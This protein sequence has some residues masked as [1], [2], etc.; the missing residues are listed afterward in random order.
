MPSPAL[1][2]TFLIVLCFSLASW[3]Q[4]RAANLGKRGQSDDMVKIVLGDARRMF[5]NHFFVKADVY[6]HSGYYPSF[7]DQ[8]Y[9]QQST[10]TKHL[11][12][13]HDEHDHDEEEHE[14]AMDFLGKPQNWVDRFGRH[15]YS[16]HH[17]HLDK[18]GEAREILPWL[19]LS[20]ELDPQR[21]ETYTVAA[22]WLREHLNKVDDAEAFLRDGLQA[23]PTSY[24][25]LFDLGKL[26]YE[27]RHNPDLARNIWELALRR[28]M[29]QDDAG[30]EPDLTAY[31]DIVANLAHL[32]EE[33][34]NLRDALEYKEM[35]VE[36]SPDPDAV[37]KQVEELKQKIAAEPKSK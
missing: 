25:I 12:E 19:R 23:N 8:A 6:F 34:G 31:G 17:S 35:E 14:K 4:P 27:N 7:I 30:K 13:V 20:A 36:V 28:W 29:E 32:E 2:L 3:L 26:Y 18:P 22:Y 9:Q 37:Q 21:I 15:F 1:L 16:S 33:Q 11:T 24:E 10:D 5:A